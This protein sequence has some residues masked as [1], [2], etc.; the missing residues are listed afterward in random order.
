MKKHLSVHKHNQLV[1]EDSTEA[2]ETIS[3][4]ALATVSDARLMTDCL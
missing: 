2:T 3:S 4:D 1:E